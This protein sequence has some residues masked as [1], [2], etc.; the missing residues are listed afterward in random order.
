MTTLP[1]PSLNF[2]AFVDASG[3]SCPQPILKAKRS[4]AALASGQVLKV[5]AT[6]PHSERDFQDFAR[7]TGNTLLQQLHDGV[8]IVHWLQRR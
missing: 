3:L 7:Q 4:L 6:D 5:M 1:N 2:D 8:H